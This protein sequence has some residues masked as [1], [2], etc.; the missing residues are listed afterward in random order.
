MKQILDRRNLSHFDN[1]DYQQSDVADDRLHSWS[2]HF[3]H[4]IWWIN[5]YTGFHFRNSL[6]NRVLSVE[7]EYL[8]LV[9]GQL[10]NQNVME[11]LHSMSFIIKFP[12]FKF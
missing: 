8:V 5:C 9:Q 3:N 4:N 1:T 7:I 10:E 12:N 11:T 6:W 2:A